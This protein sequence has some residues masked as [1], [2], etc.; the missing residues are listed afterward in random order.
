MDDYEKTVKAAQE[1]WQVWAD[2]SD[3]LMFSASGY[4]YTQFNDASPQIGPNEVRFTF[5]VLIF[6]HIFEHEEIRQR[7]LLHRIAT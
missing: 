6:T 2:V 7:V 5:S 3:S 1:A 4:M